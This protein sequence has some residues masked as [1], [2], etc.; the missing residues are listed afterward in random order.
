MQS[1]RWRT[2][3]TPNN[4]AASNKLVRQLFPDGVVFSSLGDGSNDRSQA[5]QE[6]CVLRFLGEDG[7]PY[8][9]F[10]DLVCLDLSES[11]DGY[12]PD[13]RCITAAYIRSWSE[14]QQ[15]DGFLRQGDWRKALIAGSFDGASVMLGDKSGVVARVRAEAKHF[16]AI[17]AVAHVEQLCLGDAFSDVGYYDEWRNTVQEM[18]VEFTVSGKKKFG[19]S[20]IAQELDVQLLKINSTHGIRWAAST[21]N[22]LEALIRDL[23]V[24]AVDLE[25]RSKRDIGIDVSLLSP[26]ESLVGK[27]FWQTFE[28]ET[29]GRST[30]WK[31]KVVDV[32]KGESGNS[33]ASIFTVK[34][35]DHST[36]TMSKAELVQLLT[37][38]DERLARDSRWILRGKITSA[39]FVAFS[40]F[41]LDVHNIMA[42][43][44]LT[45]Q[46]NSLIISD[47]AKHVS[48]AL[49]RVKKLESEPGEHEGLF[50]QLV[51]ANGNAYMFHTCQ[52]H[53]QDEAEAEFKEDRSKVVIR[54]SQQSYKS[55]S[56]LL[57]D[58]SKWPHN[59]NRTPIAAVVE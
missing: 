5:E 22:N 54:Q 56:C 42:V 36:M 38:H 2:P 8:N 17:H 20:Q 1:I 27:T 41:M 52:L 28:H 40:C 14:L 33:H 34:Y 13:A 11:A 10:S 15:H 25:V 53:D 57:S 37:Q 24:V 49:A 18:Y 21:R 6:A 32:D 55:A 59:D 16:L 45:F 19:L 50:R 51:A 35:S 12:S 58:R 7:K 29:N 23:P 46:K 48:K 4:A 39:R 31:A 3:L 30:R 44:S 26:C 47:I 43:L 9:T